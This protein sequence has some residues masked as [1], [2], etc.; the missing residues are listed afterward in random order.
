MNWIASMAT[1]PGHALDTDLVEVATIESLIFDLEPLGILP[2]DDIERMADCW[3]HDGQTSMAE[4]EVWL[5]GLPDLLEGLSLET[6]GIIC[7]RICPELYG[8]PD[9]Y[10]SKASRAAPRTKAK[11]AALR[12]RYEGQSPLFHPRDT[13]GLQGLEHRTPGVAAAEVRLAARRQTPKEILVV[14]AAR[15]ELLKLI[16]LLLKLLRRVLGLL[17]RGRIFGLLLLPLALLPLPLIPLCLELSL[18]LKG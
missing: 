15:R 9:S 10:G 17:S 11:M 16:R 8:D 3:A 6:W 7:L 14:I 18:P 1:A 5:E 4:L 13:D 2:P 12:R